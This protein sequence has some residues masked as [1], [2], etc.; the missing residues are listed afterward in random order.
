MGLPER[1]KLVIARAKQVI[2]ENWKNPK[3]TKDDN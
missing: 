3:K 1:N 2:I